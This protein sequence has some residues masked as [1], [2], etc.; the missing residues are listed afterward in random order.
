MH[1]W[2]SSV[3]LGAI[4]LQ[5]CMMG[6]AEQAPLVVAESRDRWTVKVSS[7][8]DVL[9]PF[10]IH[11]R[12][13][14]FLSPSFPINLSEPIDYARTWPSSLADGGVVGWTTAHASEDGHLA[15]SF[16]EVRWASLRATEGWA[17]LQH[18]SVLRTT[19][20][21]YPPESAGSFVA[22]AESP[23]L[24]VKLQQGSF[25]TV[26]PTSQED[27]AGLTPE[28]HYGNIYAMGRDPPLT[29]TLPVPP[30]M[31]RPTAYDVFVS[32]DYEIRLFGDPSAYQS[33]VP[34]LS[35]DFNADI[36]T[37]YDSVSR[38]PSQDVIADFVDGLS[39]GN[40]LGIGF[41]SASG[42]W[43]AEDAE[44]LAPTD[45]MKV[46]LLRNPRLAPMQTRVVPLK[47]VQSRPFYGNDIQVAVR[48]RSNDSVVTLKV[49]L[50]I[51]QQVL[52]TSETFQP[53]KT[54][55]FY[56]ESMPTMFLV[57]PPKN[58]NDGEPRPPILGLH[59]AGL[60]IFEEPFWAEAIPRQNNSWIVLPTGRTPWGLDWHGPS[61]QDAWQ[62]I[63][64]L[65]TI[66]KG[67]A[68]WDTWKLQDNTRVVVVGHS[69][70]GQG[71]W[72]ISSRYPDKVVA[73]VAA[74]GYIKSQAYV[75]LAASRSA[76]F[77]DPALRAILETS[78]T[79]D[80]NDLFL[81]NLADTSVLAIHGG[82][83]DNV[84]VWH[85]REYI[86]VL[87]TWNPDADASFKE[88]P[89]MPHWYPSILAND[90]VQTFLDRVS[91]EAA[92]PKLNTYTL[93]VSI[94]S[95][96][97]SYH[98]WRIESLKTPGRLA[99]L[100]VNEHETFMEVKTTNVRT[101]TLE[102]DHLHARQLVVNGISL[103]APAEKGGDLR[104][105]VN[106]SLQP[107]PSGRI[108]TALSSKGP[109]L[110]AIPQSTPS[111]SLSIASRL[112][113]ALNLYHKLDAEI[114]TNLEV[115]DRAERGTIEGATLVVI[116]DASMEFTRWC[117]ARQ[118]TP[119]T[120]ENGSL[121]LQGRAFDQASTGAIFLH[122]NPNYLD[123]SIVFL[124]GHDDEGLERVA[125]LFPIRTGVTVPDW[126]I[127]GTLAD[128]QGAAALH[129]AGVWDQEWAWNERMSWLN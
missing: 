68:A 115:M 88:D 18:H 96:S 70:G 30:A 93:T 2:Q 38:V 90:E 4:L 113:H 1:P 82:L 26:L 57:I 119:F 117:L 95:E 122:P 80:D 126:L 107:S 29:V 92:S 106:K 69:N 51:K 66:L 40:A 31:L 19:L 114:I 125:R 15:V 42:W 100:T 47:L 64:A 72:Y 62:S 41:R 85:S 45:G 44:L 49:A 7:N 109:L 8:W 94:P 17:A 65:T 37:S 32:G 28:W 10:P 127:T 128:S 118:D 58:A 52:W 67:N 102:F 74:S 121:R 89:G 112:A 11:A 34:I 63:D 56:M 79:P 36:D 99:R 87:K 24:V 108:S 16:P 61:A 111:R 73:A 48:F 71:T 22:D 129:G 35:I 84:P 54:S 43:T 91:Y 3:L 104:I 27:R 124:L 83:D 105:I 78:L 97:G 77:I 110:L 9:G 53:I 46:S 12:E 33:D 20:T 55:Y 101:C 81:S 116:G 13:Q 123:S 98:G 103:L 14:H 76:H 86:S 25:F 39:F 59:G 120:I 5:F 23:K 21:V 50:P 60:D 75:P 6:S